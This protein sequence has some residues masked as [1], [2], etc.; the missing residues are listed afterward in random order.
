MNKFR[1]MKKMIYS[2]SIFWLV[3]SCSA[4]AVCIFLLHFVWIKLIPLPPSPQL[5]D[6]IA[7]IVSVFIFLIFIIGVIC[8]IITFDFWCRPV[9]LTENEITRGFIF[10]KR[11]R[12][13][14]ITGIGLA[15]V[16]SAETETIYNDHKYGVYVCAGQYDETLIRRIGIWEALFHSELIKGLS[17]CHLSLKRKGTDTSS[18]EQLYPDTIFYLGADLDL[19]AVI[20]AWM[21]EA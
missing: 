12:K 1:L 7:S 11:I 9:F 20:K 5:F 4:F 15:Q 18:N 17:K 13:E 3:V 21:S 14:D 6:W 8:A 2:P 19:Y 16:Y 10:R